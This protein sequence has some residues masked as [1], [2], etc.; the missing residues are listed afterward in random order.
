MGSSLLILL[1]IIG[2]AALA[3]RRRVVMRRQ[4]QREKVVDEFEERMENVLWHQDEIGIAQVR[5][6]LC[7]YKSSDYVQDTIEKLRKQQSEQAGVSVSYLTS[8]DFAAL[9]RRRTSELD[10][11]FN[12]MKVKFW[13]RMTEQQAI[14]RTEDQLPIGWDKKCPRDH[15]SGCSLLDTLP[16]AHRQRC[17]H[18]LSWAWRYHLSIVQSALHMWVETDDLDPSGLFL[19]MCFFV[20][21]QYRIIVEGKTVGDLED[22]FEG[23]LLRIGRVVALLDG[24]NAPTYLTRIWTI[25]EQFTAIKLNIPV[26][27]ILPRDS[28]NSLG[29]EIDRGKE[30]INAIKESL[31]NI[32]SERAEAWQPADLEKVQTAI[33]DSVGFEAVNSCVKQTMIKWIGSVVVNK[34]EKLVFDGG[35]NEEELAALV[36]AA[37]EAD[38]D[39]AAE[40]QPTVLG[41][42]AAGH[43]CVLAI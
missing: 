5:E 13:F 31:C 6:Q 24:W 1:C 16:P 17:T 38:A 35:A 23:S 8:D 19:Y 26:Q 2:A 15:R 3:W 29:E 11:D 20:N 28:Y 37:N 4:R 30:G 22:V 10:P 36:E 32:D 7:R 12:A 42:A 40:V 14:E 21:N 9:A 41:N 43:G 39:R 33:I 25:F 18:F 27:M 34:M